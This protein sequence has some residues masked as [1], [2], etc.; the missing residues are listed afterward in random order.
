M[1]DEVLSEIK[2]RN[3]LYSIYKRNPSLAS[4]EAFKTARNKATL[5]VRDS[6]KRYFSSKL[7]SPQS[8]KNLWKTIRNLNIA[9]S[10]KNKTDCPFDCETLNNYYTSTG[11]KTFSKSLSNHQKHFKY[12]FQFTAVCENDIARCL[13]KIK[14]NAVGRDGLP[15][16][17]LKL[18]LP[19]I[20]APLT[21][22]VNHCFTTST[23]PH[24]WKLAKVIPVQ[25]KADARQISDFRP[26]SILPCLCKVCEMLLFEQIEEFVLENN[27]YRPFNLVL[28]VDIAV[29]QR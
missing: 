12:K 11:A 22:L 3:K 1:S 15:L 18:I 19:Y 24:G 5:A 13:L 17:F 21:H 6:K 28:N 2:N 10:K 23:F 8:G 20:L 16:K 29:R 14:S 4:W 25:K 26:I 9:A 27:F 7:G